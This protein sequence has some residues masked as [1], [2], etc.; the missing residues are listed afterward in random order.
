MVYIMYGAIVVF[1]FFFRETILQAVFY[2][3]NLLSVAVSEGEWCMDVT[4]RNDL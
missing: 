1:P 4:N 3:T 2:G